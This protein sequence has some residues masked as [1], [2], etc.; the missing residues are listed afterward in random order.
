MVGTILKYLLIPVCMLIF[1]FIYKKFPSVPQ[2]NI[3][4]QLVEEGIKKETGVDIDLSP[5]T[6]EKKDSVTK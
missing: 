5:N 4:E 3:V 6:P 2:D 1:G